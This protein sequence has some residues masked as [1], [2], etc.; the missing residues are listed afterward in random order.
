MQIWTGSAIGHSATN[1]IQPI[2]LLFK[3]S[4]RCHGIRSNYR[5][6][7]AR[8][9]VEIWRGF[10]I[11][12]W[13]KEICEN[14]PWF[15]FGEFSFSTYHSRSRHRASFSHIVLFGI[16]ACTSQQRQPINISLI[17][18]HLNSLKSTCALTAAR[19]G[20]QR[21]S[22]HIASS[23]VLLAHTP[24]LICDFCFIS[25]FTRSTLWHSAEEIHRKKSTE[26]CGFVKVAKDGQR[27][28]CWC[29][30]K[31]VLMWNVYFEAATL[32]IFL[33]SS[34]MFVIVKSSDEHDHLNWIPQH[35]WPEIPGCVEQK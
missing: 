3:C 5:W 19:K 20:N 34:L 27:W 16:I 32:A 10:V 4:R 33:V 14:Y 28:R 30:R 15:Q 9:C 2:L 31:S 21:I 7:H 13:K 35:N 29:R 18:I 26:M 17:Q 24:F 12:L 23:N 22:K 1:H 6:T 11:I 8:N 25:F